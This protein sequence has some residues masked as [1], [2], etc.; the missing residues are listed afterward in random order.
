[1]TG[2]VNYKEQLDRYYQE[3]VD[4]WRH[5]RN[6]Q[7]E[8]STSAR[9]RGLIKENQIFRALVRLSRIM[10]LTGRYARAVRDKRKVALISQVGSQIMIALTTSLPAEAYYDF[11]LYDSEYRAK[12]KQ[13]VHHHQMHVL[14]HSPP[15]AI[16]DAEREILHDKMAFFEHCVRNG[17]ATIPV[18]ALISGKAPA[19]QSRVVLPEIDLF[20]K[21][22]NLSRGEGAL[23]W[24]SVGGGL[25]RTDEGET[26]GHDEVLQRISEQARRLD[27]AIIVQPRVSNHPTLERLTGQSLGT[28]RTAT[29]RRRNG[30]IEV[31]S[32]IFKLPRMNSAISHVYAGGLTVAIDE[33]GRMRWARLSDPLVAMDKILR[34]PDT[35]HVLAGLEIPYWKD[36]LELCVRAH[37]TLKEIA[38]VGWDLAITENGPVLLEGNIGYGAEAIQMVDN[39][40]FGENRFARYYAEYLA[41]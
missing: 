28:P 26:L 38:F 9:I 37:A 27:T 41:P 1:M 21:P 17:L 24:F 34:H 22:V 33:N 36:L 2:K 7:R 12:A 16:P 19:G 25:Y 6:V 18:L 35:G 4:R 20:S 8:R 11:I 15:Y 39:Q 32:A 40:P 10:A 14:M 30:E 13:Y 5:Q 3:K 29:C 23:R 31:I